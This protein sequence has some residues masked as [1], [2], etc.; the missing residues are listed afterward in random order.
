M[1]WTHRHRQ[2]FLLDLV[3]FINRRITSSEELFVSELNDSVAKLTT[4]VNRIVAD[5]VAQLRQPNPEVQGAIVTL[6][7]LTG[8]LDDASA[9]LEAD[10]APAPAPAPAP[11]PPSA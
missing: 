4:A 2:S 1:F 11:T 10:D 8:V 7:K 3:R 6:D 9:Q 5:A